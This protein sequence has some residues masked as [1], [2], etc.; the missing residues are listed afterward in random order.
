MNVW[1]YLDR[2]GQCDTVV[3]A[4]NSL[5]I[6]PDER[7]AAIQELKRFAFKIN[8]RAKSRFGV[9]KYQK[10]VR[11]LPVTHKVMELTSE[12][13]VHGYT[14]HEDRADD[15]MQTLLH[16]TAHIITKVIRPNASSH[17]H[18]WKSVMRALGARPDR[19]GSAEFLSEARKKKAAASGGHKHEYTCQGCGH[20]YKT[21]RQL[22]RPEQR[23]HG[24]CGRINGRLTH[25]Q[26]R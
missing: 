3:G 14:L 21:K 4:L 22:V 23:F 15:H 6:T 7:D 10:R 20:T 13:F 17:G 11:G 19:C 12:Y 5:R 1:E 25:R 2:N 9:V 24:A 8:H 26:V 16:E 18:E